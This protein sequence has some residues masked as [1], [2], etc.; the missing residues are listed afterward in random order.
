MLY[1]LIALAYFSWK[2][3]LRIAV[4]VLFLFV[5]T[6]SLEKMYAMSSSIAKPEDY[7]QVSRIIQENRVSNDAVVYHGG[8][9]GN[10]TWRFYDPGGTIFGNPNYDPHNFTLSSIVRAEEI[11]S[12]ELFTVT[13]DTLLAAHPSVWMVISNY[14]PPKVLPFVQKW[15]D[16]Y[17]IE[18]IYTDQYLLLLKIA[19]PTVDPKTNLNNTDHE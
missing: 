11:F 17:A 13:M 3:P 7:R 18:T 15:Y 19:G 1:A 14:N 6:F 16:K 8:T 10:Q 5:S 2:R 9:C 4:I 12:E